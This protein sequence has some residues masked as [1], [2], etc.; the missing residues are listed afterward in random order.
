[1]LVAAGF[2]TTDSPS[3]TGC[4][5]Q[6]LRLRSLHATVQ[7]RISVA[8]P[9]E[10]TW[11]WDAEVTPSWG[12]GWGGSCSLHRP[13]CFSTSQPVQGE[14]KTDT[15]REQN[16]FGPDPWG[17]CSSNLGFGL[18]INRVVMAT[19]RRGSL[20]RHLASALAPPSPAPPLTKVIAASAPWGKTYFFP[21][22]L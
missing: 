20:A 6:T 11:A 8:M 4:A 13:Q 21:L 2:P 14:G 15:W 5:K 10:K 7:H 19:E 22:I 16:Q 9:R 3:A 12:R 18:P 17:F 1:M